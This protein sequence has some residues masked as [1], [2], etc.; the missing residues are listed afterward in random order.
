MIAR[1]INVPQVKISLAPTQESTPI[2]ME[3]PS[4]PR[5]SL[6]SQAVFFFLLAIILFAPVFR[7]S[8][9]A[10]PL[11]VLQLASVALLGINAINLRLSGS[12]CSSGGNPE[13][14]RVSSYAE[15]SGPV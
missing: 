7:A 15:R 6:R 3:A 5:H 8:V 13:V 10:L 14:S 4:H 1:D 2:P 9:P 12:A 11:M